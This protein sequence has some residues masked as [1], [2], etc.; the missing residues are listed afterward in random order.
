MLIR[1]YEYS[2]T[3]Q[4]PVFSLLR[5]NLRLDPLLP[6]DPQNRTLGLPAFDLSPTS[7]T[8]PLKRK[9]H[10]AESEK[11]CLYWHQLYP[12]FPAHGA[13]TIFLLHLWSPLF[14]MKGPGDLSRI[15]HFVLFSNGA[16]LHCCGS[17]LMIFA[18]DH[19]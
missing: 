12:Y 11:R 17:P 14:R 18:H 3:T 4:A 1:D 16:R 2:N 9:W 7:L 13:D 5:N 10:S 6:R 19:N 8:Q 15:N